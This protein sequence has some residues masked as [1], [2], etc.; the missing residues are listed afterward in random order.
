MHICEPVGPSHSYSRSTQE[1]VHSNYRR[2]Y[3]FT[4]QIDSVEHTARRAGS[5]VPNTYDDGIHSRGQ[6]LNYF[7]RCSIANQ[8]LLCEVHL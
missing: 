1:V 8:P 4:L 2:R 3:S 6:I 7:P 5:S